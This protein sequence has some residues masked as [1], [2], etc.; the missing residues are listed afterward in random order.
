MKDKVLL[1]ALL[2]MVL[3]GCTLRGKPKAVVPP[4]APK[5][6]A[7]PAPAPAPPPPLSIP[8]THVEL[9]KPQPVD[10]AA[11]VV[12]ITPREP[13]PEPQTAVPTRSRRT[14]PASTPTPP[15]ATPPPEAPRETFREMVSPSESKRLMDQ[16]LNR[17]REANQILDQLSKRSTLT[18]AQKN[19]IS[20]IRNFLTLSDEAE[21]HNDP[22]QADSFAERAQILAKELQREQ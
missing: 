6:A 15:A 14:T 16:A 2:S 22:R 13:E 11:L 5:P 19:V 12:D 1:T 18:P 9:P 7:T 20:T 10:P 17:R 3:A 8:Q 4:I 21:K